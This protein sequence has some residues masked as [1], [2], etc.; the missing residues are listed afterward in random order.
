MAEF[1]TARARFFSA[2]GLAI[3]AVSVLIGFGPQ[4]SR[5]DGGEGVAT[6][7]SR[8]IVPSGWVVEKVAGQPLVNYPLFAC[9]DD[10]GRLYVAEGTGKNLPGTELV[11]LNLGKFTRLEDTDGDGNFDA[12]TTFADGLVFPQGVLW[13]DGAVYVASH[14]SIWRLEDTDGDGRADK[15]EELVSRFGFNGNGCDIHGPFLGPDGW[16]YW[17]DGRHGYQCTTKEGEKIEGFAARIFRCRPDGSGIERIAGGGFDNPVELVWTSSGE[18]L[19]TMDQGTGD[20]IL[21]YVEGGVYPRDDQPCMKEFPM[22]GPPLPPVTMFSAALPVAL[23]GMC[24]I[25]TDHFGPEYRD[26]LLTAQF[27]VHRVQ[28]HQLVRDGATYRA[29]NKDFVISTDYDSH[30][31]DVLEDA[32][33]SLLV[34]DMGAW[35]NYGCPT[36]KIAKPEVK[37]T[38]Y[39]VRNTRAPAVA[40]A[41]GNSLKLESMPPSE[42]VG[43]LADSRPKVRERAADRLVKLGQPAVASLA[44]IGRDASARTLRSSATS[45]VTLPGSKDLTAENAEGRRDIGQAHHRREAVFVLSRIGTPEAHRA[46]REA[47]GDADPSVRLVAVHCCGLERDAG[48]LDA[49]GKI[50]VSDEPPVRL[51]AAEAIG[52]IGDPA[53]VPAILASL[54]RG[55][56][57]RFL[58]HS[59]IYALLRINDRDATLAALDDA[60]PNVRRA[61]LIA[62]EQMPDGGLT[63]ELVAPQLDTD[64]PELQRTALEIISRH[65]GW[66]GEINGLLG[67]WLGSKSGKLSDAQQKS[68]VGALLALSKEA[69]I[70]QLV[71]ETLGSRDTPFETRLLLPRV[72]ARCRLDQLPEQWTAVLGA[73][74]REK[75]PRLQAEVIAAIRTRGLKD[76]DGPLAELSRQSELPAELRIA[77]LGCVA[78]RQR[79]DDD[80]VQ[81]LLTHLDER[82][83][84]LLRVAAAKA[85]GSSSLTGDQ[86]LR[87]NKHVESAGPL[88]VP[89]LLPAFAKHSGPEVG[90]SLVASLKK[91]PG[92]GAVAVDDLRET[93]KRYPAEVQESADPLFKQ[94][95]SRQEEQAAYLATLTLQTLQTPPV[96]ERGRD[97]FF[98]KKVGCYGCHRLDGQGGSVGP[99]LSQI[100]RIRDPRSLLEAVVFPSSTIV[101]DYRQFV[102]A[103]S[104]G[105]IHTGMIVRDDADA[106]YL[107]TA[108]LAEIRVAR[109]DVE[110]M[111]E[112]SLSIMPQGLEKTMSPQ[113]LSDLLEYL[114]Q[115]R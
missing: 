106:I 62:L 38:I 53:G 18:L 20:C 77:A 108:E 50:V 48:S 86:L 8:F 44:N 96:P 83:E 37:G 6:D 64:D 22:T 72:I 87:L 56:A 113:E 9:F 104:S 29:I 95:A 110:D 99:D 67:E 111:K 91:S 54:R 79:L 49:L 31:S 69:N 14:P 21:H 32:D 11:K 51:K 75:N 88:I 71:A 80:S 27:N 12:S 34:V 60:N 85:L 55:G 57:D 40:D 81:L 4:N 7:E 24:R 73:V 61:G 46:V 82:T 39:R 100:G 105:T 15:Q 68:L 114:F 97:V 76:F 52:R 17:T 90:Q 74:L 13:H 43:L 23:C 115:R 112:S 19:G 1:G 92:V 78:P 10:Q 16:L 28:Q 2:G 107:R 65:E 36:S 30:P 47:L 84:P 89:L 66:A 101:P 58:D 59:L 42:L 103:T 3:V 45:A 93:L 33:G 5:R 94:L 26:A 102:I 63:R 98:S 41:W 70:Q 25:T 35:F 109:S